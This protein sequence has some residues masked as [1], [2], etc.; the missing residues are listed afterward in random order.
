MKL[1]KAFRPID[2]VRHALTTA[3]VKMVVEEGL[4]TNHEITFISGE[5]GSGVTV[6]LEILKLEAKKDSRIRVVEIEPD[7]ALT[8]SKLYRS[9]LRKG[10][11]PRESKKV[12]WRFEEKAEQIKEK[13]AEC[14][15]AGERVLIVVDDAVLLPP[16]S[17]EALQHLSSI[18]ALGKNYGPAIVLAVDTSD[19]R[20]L[21]WKPRRVITSAKVIK[22]QGLMD[23]E[24]L[25]YLDKEIERDGLSLSQEAKNQILERIQSKFPREINHAALS[26]LREHRKAGTMSKAV[27]ESSPSKASRK[28]VAAGV[29]E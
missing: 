2:D 29:A 3:D 16:K 15:M 4:A 22:L 17:W 10:G 12:A 26:V 9:I 14:F 24:L 13:L 5:S 27:A 18:M 8:M 21:R 23:D 28:P 11:L 6:A 20:K 7:P 25:K 1:R 19:G